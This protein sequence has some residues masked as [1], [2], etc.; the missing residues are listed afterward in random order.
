LG[1]D[2]VFTGIVAVPGLAPSQARHYW[3]AGEQTKLLFFT[4]NGV[5][6]TLFSLR[7]KSPSSFLNGRLHIMQCALTEKP[8]TLIKQIN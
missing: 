6:P 8:T 1:L 7:S 2:Y 4:V 3:L 5:P